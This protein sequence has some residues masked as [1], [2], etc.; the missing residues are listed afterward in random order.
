MR[1]KKTHPNKNEET[2]IRNALLWREGSVTVPLSP[3]VVYFDLCAG[4]TE[5]QSLMIVLRLG[6]RVVLWRALQ[7]LAAKRC[8]F[9]CRD[10]LSAPKSRDPVLCAP[11][12]FSRLFS[13]SVARPRGHIG[14]KQ[15]GPAE[16]VAPRVSSLKICRF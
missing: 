9:Y 15:K 3:D 7:S 1:N 2:L 12:V 8:A 4:R 10:A 13:P 16:Q 5:S 11:L 14:S 6:P